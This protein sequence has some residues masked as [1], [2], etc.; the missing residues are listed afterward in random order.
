MKRNSKSRSRAPEYQDYVEPDWQVRTAPD[1]A[2][3]GDPAPWPEPEPAVPAN[4]CRSLFSTAATIAAVAAFL[5]CLGFFFAFILVAKDMPS[6][7]QLESAK[8]GQS[9]KIYDRNGGLLF[10]I[11]D[12][13]SA[14]AGRKTN[15]TPDRIPDVLRKATIATEDPNF[16]SNLG[17]DPYGVARAVY[18]DLRYGRTIVGG[19]TIT[20][21]LVKTAVLTPGR[22]WQRKIHEAILAL[23]VTQRYS[24]DQILAYYLNAIFYGNLS[25]GIE[26]ASQS[27]FNKDVSQLDLAEASLLAG[28]P[29]APALYDPC[30]NPDAAL[31]R[32]KT[33]LELMQKQG[34]VDDA[35][36]QA[37]SAEMEQ[38]LHS[39]EFSKRCNTS[40]T[41][42]SP[43]FVEYVR[44]QLEQQYGPEVV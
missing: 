31:E 38:V 15:I 1:A 37:A 9:T 3:M 41:I 18:Y 12:P 2:F 4:G 32:Q 7:E 26:A 39:E 19:S 8:V 40:F 29:Q 27:Y 21:Q 16:Y 23:L 24:K 22:T 44:Q 10:E 11:F 13:N 6:Q 33:V 20:Q 14:A 43:H 35:Q 28:L 5:G 36:A 25:Y 42:K 34:Y 30:D 17:V